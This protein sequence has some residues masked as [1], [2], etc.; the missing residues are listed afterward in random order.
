[1]LYA[2]VLR[3]LLPLVLLESLRLDDLALLL[4]IEPNPKAVAGSERILPVVAN[5]GALSSAAG[6]S[7]F[8]STLAPPYMLFNLL[9]LCDACGAAGDCATV[10]ARRARIK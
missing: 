5:R 2:L 9:V 10:E 7:T 3:S 6:S 4:S 1:M 8:S